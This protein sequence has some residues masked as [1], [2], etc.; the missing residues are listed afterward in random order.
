MIHEQLRHLAVPIDSIQPDPNNARRR[1]PRNLD[2]IKSSLTEFGQR[3]PII[4]SA[5]TK[6]ISA[7]NGTY[8]AAKALG[9][10]EIA[11]L[12]TDDTDKTAKRFALADNRSG[13]LS[14]WDSE[15][16]TLQLAE[17]ED[18][19]DLGFDDG[20]IDD[21]LNPIK[22]DREYI[23]QLKPHPRNYQD[24]PE[25]QLKQII[26][27]IETHGFYRNVVV[28]RD[29][30]IL[31]GHGVVAAA[32][33]MK[34]SRV[35]VIRLDLDYDDP[36]ALKVLT[37]DN[38]ISNLAVVDDRALTTMLKEIM[39]ADVLEGTGFDEQQLA[40]M[41]L[42]TRTEAEIQDKTSDEWVGLP[43]FHADPDPLKIIINFKTAEDRER[44]AS[45][46]QLQMR[47]EITVGE[48][49]QHEYQYVGRQSDKLKASIHFTQT[50][51]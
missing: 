50:K 38:E 10:T 37:S 8:E 39:D 1:T 12:M 49:S 34:L 5:S 40:A 20:D 21:L 31:A 13:E 3:K 17:Y 9:W 6:Y 35:P 43:A 22:H 14:E 7:G 30:Y 25:D 2:V 44:F 41:L 29:N 47:G 19:T 15:E 32:K 51:E 48:E 28:C 42:T 18:A 24:H 33:R 36:R 26:K 16:L 23:D 27:S 11:A 45:E 46:Y 4:V